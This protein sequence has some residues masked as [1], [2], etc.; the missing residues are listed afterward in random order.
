MAVVDTPRKRL[1]DTGIDEA[2]GKM[3]SRICGFLSGAPS[4][5]I[6]SGPT[7]C[8]KLTAAQHCVAHAGYGLTEVVNQSASS[9][10]VITT[11]QR[12][13][14]VLTSTGSSK[15][16]VIVVTG[17]DGMDGGL[18]DLVNCSRRCGKHVIVLVNNPT[19]FGALP[20][21]QLY[22]CSWQQPWSWTAV[23]ACIETV[24]GSGLLTVQEKGALARNCK[25]IR[26]LKIMAEQMVS[27]KRHGCNDADIRS[28]L[29]DTPAHRWYDALE[30][31]K[32]TRLPTERH[33]IEWLGGSYLG[34]LQSTSLDAA[35]EFAD[36]LVVADLLQP[37][38]RDSFNSD[39]FS[40]LVLQSAM[41]LVSHQSGLKINRLG[42]ESIPRA[43]KRV[44][45]SFALEG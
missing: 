3:C 40:A 23:S 2:F 38:D 33:H 17:A 25:D 31:T 24:D 27:A 8:G 22:R 9:K 19:P 34:G 45:Y 15:P 32:G 14:S 43:N 1:L 16:S 4:L 26:Q 29:C 11:I 7:G 37:S 41:P 13:G 10:Q 36:S 21:A 28:A 39:P 18:S 12:S 20:V 30:I 6:V 5:L 35:A 42:L 44:R